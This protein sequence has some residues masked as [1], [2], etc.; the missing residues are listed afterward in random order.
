[1]YKQ[2]IFIIGLIIGGFLF[3]RIYKAFKIYTFKKRMKKGRKAE[4]SAIKLLMQEGYKIIST[5]KSVPVIT[6]IDGKPYKN[7]VKADFIVRKGLKKYVAEIKTGDKAP[8]A[9]NA[10][11]RRQL[12][13]YYLAYKPT[14]IILV[15]MNERRIKTIE[16]S[17]GT[18]PVRNR[19]IFILMF[20]IFLAAAFI[21]YR[22]AVL[23]I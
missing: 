17:I 1:M 11:T 8:Q 16:F 9:N 10:A 2:D 3:Y 15:D 23:I 21:S 20:L 14:G 22:Y 6:Y 13:E 5:Q 12:L 18:N 4:K 19:L 7:Y